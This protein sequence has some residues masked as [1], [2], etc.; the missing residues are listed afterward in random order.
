MPF[1]TAPSPMWVELTLP[2]RSTSMAV[3][4]AMML[5]RRI[6]SGA[7]LSSWGRRMI[8]PL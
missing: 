2:A 4:M 7:L 3:F 1:M 5:K 6:T 8:L